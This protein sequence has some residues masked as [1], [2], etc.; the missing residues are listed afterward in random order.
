VCPC[1]G[2]SGRGV[3]E[4]LVPLGGRATLARSW[5]VSVWKEGSDKWAAGVEQGALWEARHA[6]AA[7]PARARGTGG[8]PV[9]VCVWLW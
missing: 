1:G 3:G 7:A 8:R 4:G 2:G 5:N 6:Q 9:C